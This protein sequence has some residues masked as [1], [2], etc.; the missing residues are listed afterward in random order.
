MGK[1]IKRGSQVETHIEWKSAFSNL[2]SS[3]NM[4]ACVML[5]A[6]SFHCPGD[7]ISI[8]K[9]LHR[10]CCEPLAAAEN[11]N[12]QKVIHLQLK[13]RKA[14]SPTHKNIARKMRVIW[15]NGFLKLPLH[16]HECKRVGVDEWHATRMLQCS[17][18][19]STGISFYSDAGANHTWAPP[20]VDVGSE[21]I[22][23][24]ICTEH[25]HNN[26]HLTLNYHGSSSHQLLNSL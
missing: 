22:T 8:S 12:I 13:P 9:E 1:H 25:T 2:S 23:S 18:H 15:S 5:S 3:N 20:A 16:Q 19:S 14:A 10:L 24:H 21:M 7:I 17:F 26:T 4:C 6:C 11:G